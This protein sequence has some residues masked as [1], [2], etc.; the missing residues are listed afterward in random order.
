MEE[1]K[2]R[3]PPLFAIMA[4]LFC[5]ALGATTGGALV[6]LQD[7]YY[8]FARVQVTKRPEVHGFWGVEVIDE[9]K[10]V[11]VAEQSN[12]SFRM[13]HVHGLGVGLLILVV[14][15]AI[16]N[17]PAS[18]KVRKTLTLL[19]S[20]GALYPPGWLLFGVLIPYYGFKTLRNPIEYGIF[21][22][23]GGAAIVGIWGTLF[24]YGLAWAKRWKGKGGETS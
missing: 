20:L 10:I 5:F 4:S 23:F 16:A 22:P 18:E 13:L 7:W 24:F 15:L 3:R 1:L 2:F 19:V 8:E 17:L 21:L 14:A 9:Q 6:K 11:E 12:R